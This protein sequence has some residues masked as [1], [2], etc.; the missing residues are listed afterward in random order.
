MLFLTLHIK[1][2][3]QASIGPQTASCAHQDNVMFAGPESKLRGCPAAVMTKPDLARHVFNL[4]I[5]RDK[6]VPAHTYPITSQSAN[7]VINR[8]TLPHHNPE[9]LHPYQ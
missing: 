1:D 9:S 4:S 3:T 5:R 7:Y 8:V 6:T 2:G